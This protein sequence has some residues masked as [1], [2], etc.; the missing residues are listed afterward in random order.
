[1]VRKQKRAEK[2]G[3]WFDNTS[4]DSNSNENRKEEAEW[5][6]WSQIVNESIESMKKLPKNAEE[7]LSESPYLK[8]FLDKMEGSSTRGLIDRLIY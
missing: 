6:F 3:L 2:G 4:Y 5:K 8:D 7:L 1:M